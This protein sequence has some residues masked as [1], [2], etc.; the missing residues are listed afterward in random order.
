MNNLNNL[1]R[2]QLFHL[3]L[4]VFGFVWLSWTFITDGFV[5]DH[6]EGYINLFLKWIVLVCGLI[7]I[8]R[9]SASDEETPDEQDQGEVDHG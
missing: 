3:I 5:P 8:S 6:G 9:L 4:L 7:I 2:N 1:L